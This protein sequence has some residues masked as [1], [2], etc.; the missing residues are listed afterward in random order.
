MLYSELALD[1][2]KLYNCTGNSTNMELEYG[3]ITSPLL[4]SL[5][6]L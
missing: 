2:Y 1:T 6:S 3:Q 4:F 5:V